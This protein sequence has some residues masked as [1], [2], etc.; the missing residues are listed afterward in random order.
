MFLRKKF[1]AEINR[2]ILADEYWIILDGCTGISLAKSAFID[3]NKT[4]WTIRRIPVN[5]FR[6]A[7]RT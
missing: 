5:N 4:I 1:A 3:D 6:P 2:N 7:R